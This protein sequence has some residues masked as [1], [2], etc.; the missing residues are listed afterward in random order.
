VAL[1]ARKLRRLEAWTNWR[2]AGGTRQAVI[3]DAIS[4]RVSSALENEQLIVT[5]PL[6]SPAAGSLGARR[7]IAVDQSDAHSNLALWSQEYDNAIYQ[8]RG[9]CTVTPNTVIAPD[10]TLTGDTIAGCANA[11]NDIFQNVAGLTVGN[12]Y[13]PSFFVQKITAG[14][15]S[16][17]FTNPATSANGEWRV[18]LDKLGS[19]WERIT[20]GHPAVTIITEFTANVSGVAGLFW[21][22][23]S[24]LPI[25]FNLWGSQLDPGKVSTDYIPTTNAQV[26]V[27]AVFDEYRIVDRAV[28]DQ[29]SVISITAAPFRLTDLQGAGLVSRTDSDNV[30]VFDFEVLGLTPAEIVTNWVLPALAA[31]GFGWISIGTI[32]PTARLDMTFAWD[33]PLGI[34]LRIASATQS[35]LDLRKNGS[36]GYFIDIVTKVNNAAQQ[37]DLRVDKN[38]VNV[39]RGESSIEQATR[40]YPR[41]A[42]QDEF[43]ATMARATWLVGG[44]GGSTFTLSDP[45]GGKPPVQCPGQLTGRYIRKVDGTLT[46]ITSSDSSNQQIV[47]AS[48]AGIAN[49]DLVQVR[50]DA[51]GTDLTYLDDPA[52]VAAYGIK[53]AVADVSDVPATNNLVKNSAMR[54]WPGSS[55][56]PPTNWTAVGAPTI[57]KQTAAPFTAIGGNSIKVTSTADG[58]GVI[59]DAVPIF[60]TALNAYLSGYAKLWVA[61]GNAR[62]ELVINT[63]TGAKIFPA[64]PDVASPSVLGQWDDIGASGFDANGV[65]ATT[66]Q[67]RIVQNG[68]T[69]S[70]FYVDAAQITQ[71]ATQ[72]PWFEGSGGTR[73]W[74]EAN[75]A[76]R[77]GSNPLVSYTVPLVDLEQYDSAKWSESA[78]ILG[79][80]A[81]VVDPRLAID[82]VTRIVGIERDYLNPQ[83]TSV[84][85]SNRYDDLTD[86]LAQTVRPDRD[87]GQ[88]E[89]PLTIPQQPKISA[90]FDINGQLI[91]NS[92]GDNDVVNQKIAWATGA[93]PSAATVR[94]ATAIAQQNIS[95]LATG[96]SYP[97][98]T[99]V[100]IAGFAYNSRGF[101]SSPLAVVSESRQ[102]AIIDYTP[103]ASSLTPV[104]IVSALPGLGAFVGEI[105]FLTTDK[106]LYRWTGS[107]WTSA[108]DSVDITGQ[109][110]TAQIADLAVTSA[111]V[112]AAAVIAGKIAANAVGSTEIASLAVTNAKIA[113]N[114]VDTGKLAANAVTTTELAALAVTGAKIAAATITAANIAAHT[115]SA[116]E[117][118]ALTITAAEIATGT[119]TTNKIAAGAISAGKISIGSGGAA[120]NSD[121]MTTDITAW[122]NI[123]ANNASIV[124][125]TDGK[126]GPT[127]IRSSGY[128]AYESHRQAYDPAKSYR[129]RA[130]AR[131]DATANGVLYIGMGVYNNSNGFADASGNYFYIAASGL[132]ASTTWTEYQGTLPANRTWATNP[133]RMSIVLLLNYGGTVGYMEAQDVRLEEV[134]PGTLIQ[135]G[136]IITN[137]LAANAVTAAKIAADTITAAEIAANAITSA[138][139][140]ANSV[141][142]GKIAALS[143]TAAEIAALTIT[144]AKIAA[145]TITADKLVANSIT[146]GQIQAGA[147]STTELAAGAVTAAKIAAGTI[148]AAQIAAGTITATELA[149]GSITVD[150]LVVNSLVDACF[151]Q[152]D[153]VVHSIAN[154]SPASYD[155]SSTDVVDT[156]GMHSAGFLAAIIVQRTGGIVFGTA[157]VDWDGNTVGFRELSITKNDVTFMD[158]LESA[159]GIG[160]GWQTISFVD[161][162][163]TAGDYYRVVVSQS[164]GTTRTVSYQTF[165][166]AHLKL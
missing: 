64:L 112:G 40:V 76:L 45:A 153:G 114:A 111:K 54:T 113:A 30:V 118:A 85:L 21:R 55:S 141:V 14:G 136:A 47:V 38:L 149:V 53:A 151:V 138:E 49:G 125:L 84:T 107:A 158:M 50:A 98:G 140:A 77:T 16:I 82:I 42:T 80:N 72:Q 145:G 100:F 94:A 74:Q 132:T 120:L 115:I 9:T 7:V 57:A 2:A 162:S 137:K 93:A 97:Q 105:V 28:D 66:A 69:A 73:L 12:R 127:A 96:S 71:S 122:D 110:Q 89:E 88:S 75:E 131:R 164:S 17:L 135:D 67:I 65:A 148:T 134:L 27:P 63:P 70:V 32:T 23:L 58:Q 130:W 20:R 86:V 159:A 18:N 81:R 41:G 104:K 48:A 3:D 143:I 31:A 157:Q 121:P 11:G 25:T 26:I 103:F 124:A 109:I 4:A 43:A 61:S 133:E 117:I 87:P 19:G 83:A 60:P 79:A 163:P 161:Y 108:T 34:L 1:T 116:N 166:V 22:S 15:D 24:S 36:A 39:T 165:R 154:N 13:E 129:V 101:E 147:I 52:A 8:K 51:A 102:G 5:I 142:A 33:T 160:D 92:F 106:K 46:L 139:L 37:A 155:W 99:T 146:A 90:S 68:L 119:I 156:A 128:S 59:S 152:G 56:A 91:I 6:E 95:G 150:K 144:G 62:V 10:G 29:A 123:G 44:L 78:L 126:V 35:E